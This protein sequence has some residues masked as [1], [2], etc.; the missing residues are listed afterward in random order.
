MHLIIVP[1]W[2]RR[3]CE[4]TRVAERR[5]RLGQTCARVQRTVRTRGRWASKRAG[6]REGGWAVAHRGL[7]ARVD[8]PEW[9]RLERQAG[10]SEQRHLL[11]RAHKAGEWRDA[12]RASVRRAYRL[13]ARHGQW[14]IAGCE[15][16][17][18]HLYNK[19]TVLRRRM[20]TRPFHPQRRGPLAAF[21]TIR[22]PTAAAHLGSE[23]V[24]HHVVLGAI[25]RPRASSCLH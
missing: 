9:Q 20:S 14:L 16:E 24:S 1:R 15:R 17:W 13:S 8:A 11:K 6:T 25:F 19:L 3:Y 22:Q 10:L 2:L 4:S 23:T 5:C 21:Y 12:R 18:T 7:R